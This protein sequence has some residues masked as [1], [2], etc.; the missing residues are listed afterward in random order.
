MRLRTGSWGEGDLLCLYFMPLTGHL[1][2]HTEQVAADFIKKQ[3]RLQG[4]TDTRSRPFSENGSHLALPGR[5]SIASL[6]TG[7]SVA[8]GSM[9]KKIL[10]QTTKNSLAEPALCTP[11][12]ISLSLK[13]GQS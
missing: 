7:H 5:G 6:V 12:P 9:L 2:S 13:L 1:L 10:R 3:C 8:K 4:I 11:N